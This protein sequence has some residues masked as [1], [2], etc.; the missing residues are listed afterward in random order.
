MQRREMLLSLGTILGASVFPRGWAAAEEKRKPKILYFTK[1]AGYPHSVVKRK[2]GKLA[3]SERILTKLG[4]KHGFEVECSQ[5]AAVFD[6]DLGKY[7]LFA[8]YTSGDPLDKTQKQKLLDAIAAGKPFVG[9]HAAT[10]SFRIKDSATR[11]DP[12]IA[13]IG[14]E[15]I[16]H[17]AQQKVMMKVVSPKFPGMKGLG[18]GF[19]MLEEWYTFRKYAKDLHVI[20]LQ[21][22]AGMKGKM[23]QRPPFPATWARMHGKGRVFYTSMGHREDVW[24]GKIFQQVLLGGISWALGRVEADVTPNLDRVAPQA[25]F[26][27]AD[28][29]R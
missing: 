1:S 4:A 19:K 16:V 18:E 7:D 22:T 25:E 23:Y 17:G 24:T 15:F 20:L 11:I 28:A 21:E 12:Y 29:G 3:F 13:M 14:G 27:D 5:D 26:I 6:G 9:I 10:D 2:K 8:F